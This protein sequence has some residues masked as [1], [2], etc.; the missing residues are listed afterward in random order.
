MA[1]DFR[2]PYKRKGY[3]P[4]IRRT[5]SIFEHVFGD[6][7]GFL[8]TFTGRQARFE[9][10]DARHNELAAI[11]QRSFSYA[12]EAE[13]AAAYLLDESRQQRDAYFGTHL[14]REPSSRRA[15]NAAP[16]V[17]ALWLDEDEGCFPEGGPQPTAVVAS[18]ATRRHLYWRLA[19]PVAVEW[20]VAMNR[21]LAAWAEG[22]TGKAALATVLRVPGTMNYKRH[23]QVDPVTMQLTG[24]SE[25]AWDPEALEQAVPEAPRPELGFA[26]PGS[27]PYEKTPYDGPKVELEGYL[28]GVEVLGELPDRLGKK[29]QIVCPW[30]ESHSG[31]DRT[32]T[33]IGKRA[34]GGPWFHC[35]HDHCQGRSWRD[36]K[37]AVRWNRQFTVD[38]PGFAGAAITVEIR[39]D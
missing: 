22:D 21:R 9:R 4:V 29:F 13:Q 1:V 2:S 7:E 32:G 3:C 30:V 37:R 20:A 23:L 26:S 6:A 33:R 8:V 36:F 17:R 5:E 18:S 10:P 39:C 38:R 28:V 35:D 19:P 14:F 31:G 12:G 15:A 24:A 34:G 27:K 11:R 16:T 25:A